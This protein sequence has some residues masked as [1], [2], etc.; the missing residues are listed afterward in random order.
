[1]DTNDLDE[2]NKRLNRI[3]S[4]AISLENAVTELQYDIR[5][6]KFSQGYCE[7][8]RKDHK[9]EALSGIE[10]IQKVYGD[11]KSEMESKQ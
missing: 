11:L 10:L 6:M 7:E 2:L 5:G 9:K 1:M 4:L 8:C 3:Y